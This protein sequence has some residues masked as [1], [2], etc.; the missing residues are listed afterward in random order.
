LEP[1]PDELNLGD[2]F[3]SEDVGLLAQTFGLLRINFEHAVTDCRCK[4]LGEDGSFVEGL[5]SLRGS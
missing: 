2:S 5:I 1:D 3:L 4:H